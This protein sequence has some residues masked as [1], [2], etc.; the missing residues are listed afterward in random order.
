LRYLVKEPAFKHALGYLKSKTCH[1]LRID[2]DRAILRGVRAVPKELEAS[3]AYAISAKKLYGFGLRKNPQ[4]GAVEETG[5]VQLTAD[6]GEL[7]AYCTFTIFTIVL[8]SS[9]AK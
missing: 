1:A 9:R 8:S 4:C 2:K 5:G 7:L 3:L 6:S